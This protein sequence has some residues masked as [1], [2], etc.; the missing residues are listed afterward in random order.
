MLYD[1]RPNVELS[2][3]DVRPSILINLRKRFSEAGIKHYKSVLADLTYP[4]I[5]N[6]FPEVDLV[7]ADVPCT[8]SGVWSR[9]PEQLY[10]FKK[11]RI[12][13][14]TALQ[15]KILTNVIP[16]IKPGGQLI[17]ITCSIFR[18]ENE[19]MVEFLKMQHQMEIVKMQVLEGYSIKADTMFAALMTKP[20]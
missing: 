3:S 19:D 11:D 8:G 1:I 7:I 9:T 4:S 13:Y 5:D 2:V 18:R 6:Y 16:Y 20:L 14:Y 10:Y 15:L 12:A 17:Y